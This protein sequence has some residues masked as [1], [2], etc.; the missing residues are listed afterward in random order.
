MLSL[1]QGQSWQWIVVTAFWRDDLM[2][3]VCVFG[4][5]IGW[6]VAR[7]FFA[8]V[9]TSG[10][11]V[12]KNDQ[13]RWQDTLTT[14]LSG[15]SWQQIVVGTCWNRN[16]TLVMHVQCR[17]WLTSHWRLF[18]RSGG[19]RAH[20]GQNEQ[21]MWQD[22]Q[23]DNPSVRSE[24]TT[25]SCWNIWKRKFDVGHVFSMQTLDGN[26]L[27]IS[28]NPIDAQPQRNDR[29]MTEQNS[30]VLFSSKT[31]CGMCHGED[32]HS[33]WWQ[34]FLVHKPHSLWRRI[35]PKDLCRGWIALKNCIHLQIIQKL[36]FFLFVMSCA[37]NMSCPIV[38]CHLHA[39]QQR[40]TD[41]WQLKSLE[42]I[43]RSVLRKQT[44]IILFVGLHRASS[45]TSARQTL[46]W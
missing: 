20:G 23:A 30:F 21:N 16:L 26:L 4:A 3:D 40:T 27:E 38:G 43:L 46:L 5:D 44:E 31:S 41:L 19:I 22:T 32:W 34:Q 18:C 9:W 45:W 2:L 33:M 10:H 14:L 36:M 42:L 29:M 11:M 17:F 15:Q 7:D 12:A 37:V 1:N 25:D 39:E 28:G 24:L 8:E 13:I 35:A 6:Q